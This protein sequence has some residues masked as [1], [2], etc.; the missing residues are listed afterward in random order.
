MRPR[1]LLAR[2]AGHMV[3]YCNH[4]GSCPEAQQIS[5]Y[6]G[7]QPMYRRLEDL[8]IDELKRLKR[9]LELPA[10]VDVVGIALQG[11]VMFLLGLAGWKNSWADWACIGAGIGGLILASFRFVRNRANVRERAECIALLK[12]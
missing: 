5:D 4:G 1:E 3:L 7:E 8:S 6:L 2:A 12:G 10:P 9:T 11:F